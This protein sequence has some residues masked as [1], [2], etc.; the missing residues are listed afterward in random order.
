MKCP[1]CPAELSLEDAT[2]SEC[3]WKPTDLLEGSLQNIGTINAG[4]MPGVTD[5]KAAA[6]SAA[7]QGMGTAYALVT[8]GLITSD[9]WLEWGRHFYEAA[10][11]PH[12]PI[13]RSMS[14]SFS[15]EAEDSG[16][17]P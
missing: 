8:L 11:I 1:R 10:G 15:V 4:R 3:G 9:Q 14:Y 12:E 17:E 2:C 13:K 5:V 7:Y 16:D 6:E